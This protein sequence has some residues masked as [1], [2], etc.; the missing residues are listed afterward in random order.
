MGVEKF[1]RSARALPV[2]VGEGNCDEVQCGA[3]KV[4]GVVAISATMAMG[5]RSFNAI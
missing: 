4:F 5:D 3:N 1:R 2:A